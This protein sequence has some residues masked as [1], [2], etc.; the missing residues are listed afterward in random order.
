[1]KGEEKGRL[2]AEVTRTCRPPPPPVGKLI[3]PLSAQVT[4]HNESERSQ[5]GIHCQG[6]EGQQ[7]WAEWLHPFLI[8]SVRF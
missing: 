1:M 7:I 6:S 5:T 4:G 2:T 8:C 3:P